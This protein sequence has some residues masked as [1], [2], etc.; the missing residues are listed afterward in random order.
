MNFGEHHSDKISKKKIHYP[1]NDGLM[2]Y[3][4]NYDRTIQTAVTYED[5]LR[6]TDH[7]PILDKNGKDT[8]WEGVLYPY[9]EMEEIHNGLLKIYQRLRSD[10]NEEAAGHLVV[11][12]IDYCTFGNS[13][14]FRVKIRNQYNDIHDY[15]YV[16]KADASR[17]YGLELEYLLSPNRVYFLVCGNTLIEEHIVGIPGDIFL[18]RYVNEYSNKKRIA[19]EF[20]KFNERCFLRLL[21]DQRSYNFVIEMTPDFDEIKYRIRSIDFDQQCY[22]GRMNLYKPQFFK[23]N[24]QYVKFVMDNIEQSSI[25]QYQNEERSI[26]AKR[27]IVGSNR[28]N[29]LLAVMKTDHIAPKEKTEQLKTEIYNY[30]KDNSLKKCNTMGEIVEAVLGFTL[31]NYEK[32][33]T[34]G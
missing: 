20:V 8:L 19:K 11:D 22:E 32:K 30:L 14:P 1:I 26:M 10:G 17:I 33:L 15:F 18:E 24:L 7:F 27:M 34:E 5:L 12:S 16:K 31:R 21:G 6:F 25:R 29:Q 3:L 9:H 23:E 4:A 2:S 28:L 13:H